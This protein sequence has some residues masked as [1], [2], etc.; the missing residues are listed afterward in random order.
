MS[1]GIKIISKNRRA[2]FDYHISD[3]FEA[4]MVL[5]GSEVKSLRAG[6]SN[7]QDC[8]CT[9][10]DSEVFLLNCHIAPYKFASHF[11]HEPERPKKLLLNGKEIQKIKKALEQQGATIVVSKMYF[12]AGRVRIEIGIGKGKKNFDKRHDIADRESK[13]R[14]QRAMGKRGED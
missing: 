6:K 8:Y 4:G 7:L 13:R 9:I 5:L 11:N 1:D 12:K 10:K 14:M 3:R 2:G